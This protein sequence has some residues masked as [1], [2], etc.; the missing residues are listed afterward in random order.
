MS[1]T[2]CGACNLSWHTNRDGVGSVSAQIWTAELGLHKWQ[3]PT[4]EQIK[5]R[6][7]QKY[8]LA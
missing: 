4:K 8:V 2:V 7:R 6:L 3:A 5:Q 1:T